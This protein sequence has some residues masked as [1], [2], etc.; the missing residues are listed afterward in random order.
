VSSQDHGDRRNRAS[1]VLGDLPAVRLATAAAPTAR[2]GGI[3]VSD[4]G[5]G[6]RTDV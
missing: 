4:A 2:A 5:A 1:I 6:R 3:S